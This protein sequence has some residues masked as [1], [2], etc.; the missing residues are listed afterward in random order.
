MLK[1]WLQ[2]SFLNLAIVA[3]LGVI[4]RYKIIYPLP[5]ADQKN[6]L[7]AHSHF[8][9]AGWVTQA[10][11]SLLVSRLGAGNTDFFKKYRPLLIGN[12]LTAYGMLFTFPFL[13]YGLIAIIFSTL[14]IFVSYW[15]A[16]CYWRDLNR[17][18]V[19][20]V[21][22][23]WFKAAVVFNAISSV[24]PFMLAGMILAKSISMEWYLASIYYFL[25]FQYNGWFFFACMGLLAN[26]LQFYGVNKEQLMK[27]FR[28]FVYAGIPA[29]LLSI[30]WAKLPWWLY[31][32]AIVAVVLQLSGWFNTIKLIRKL[33]QQHLL[34]LDR[35]PY[36]LLGLCGLAYSIKL[37]LQT[38]S[39]IPSL[40]HF[41]YGFRP[42]VIGYLHLVLL[43]VITLFIIGYIV[44][45]K[46]INI[47]F[48]L[49]SGVILAT[50]GILLNEIF[51]MIQGISDMS[52][53]PIPSVNFLLLLAAIVL[54][55][56]FLIV[57]ISQQLKQSKV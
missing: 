31:I 3:L 18:P 54:F 40:S 57:F 39:V 12:L 32:F 45:L 9:F 27:I 38:A 4:M 25:H 21:S 52:Y 33:L 23:S 22:H 5:L 47:N 11:M 13:G 43:G 14:S 41:A 51:L 8:A 42:I 53:I 16:F 26:Q 20:E 50:A 10:L 15:F 6:L 36:I 46:L 35:L 37:V 49:R 29:Y 2:I 48:L 7:H 28:L 30:L 55:L 34:V 44:A 24:G 17:E 56:G 1:K 19:K